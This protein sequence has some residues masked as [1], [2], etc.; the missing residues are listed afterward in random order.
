VRLEIDAK[1]VAYTGD[2]AWTEHMPD[3]ARDADLFISEGSFHG[4]SIPHHTSYPDLQ[5]HRADL[6][7]GRMVLTH[8]SREMMPHAEE[9][10]EEAAYDGRVVEL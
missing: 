5:A 7:H 6:T 3:L 2:S 4:P 10:P 1:V 8:F 9:V